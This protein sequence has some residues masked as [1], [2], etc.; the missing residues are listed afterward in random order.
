M[1]HEYDME[2]LDIEYVCMSPYDSSFNDVH[3]MFPRDPL[4]N[5]L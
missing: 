3:I 2:A 4:K 5:T 1:Q